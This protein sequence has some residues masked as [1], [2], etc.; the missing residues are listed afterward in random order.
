MAVHR[1][2]VIYQSE[3]LFISPDSTGYHFTGS[4]GSDTHGGIIEMPDGSKHPGPWGLMTPPVNHFQAFGKP[5]SAQKAADPKRNVALNDN[6]NAVGWQCGDD[7]PNWNPV[8]FGRM[9]VDSGDV[10]E[11][12]TNDIGSAVAKKIHTEM[13][14]QFTAVVPGTAGDVT[15]TADGAKNLNTLLNEHNA[16]ASSDKQLTLLADDA[17]LDNWRLFHK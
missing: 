5:N 2:R 8:D 1:N 17:S 4:E 10:G 3:A 16:S 15:I 14:V 7:W 6:G 11:K 13:D 12:S 9:P